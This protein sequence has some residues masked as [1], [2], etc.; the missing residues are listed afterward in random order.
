[1]ATKRKNK[2]FLHSEGNHQK[3]TKDSLLIFANDT[4]DKALSKICK[5]LIQLITKKANEPTKNGQRS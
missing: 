3:K 4:S 1:M 2:N 5:K